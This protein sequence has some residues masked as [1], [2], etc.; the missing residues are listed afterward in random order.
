MMEELEILLNKYG[1]DLVCYS[2]LEIEN[3]EM[4][5]S[6]ANGEF[7]EMIIEKLKELDKRNKKK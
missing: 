6:K 7:A 4:V 5:R 2:P 1:Y 3:R